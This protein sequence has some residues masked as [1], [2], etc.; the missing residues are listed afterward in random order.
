MKSTRRCGGAANTARQHAPLITRK[1][2]P[3]APTSRAARP[4]RSYSAFVRCPGALQCTQKLELFGPGL[5]QCRPWRDPKPRYESGC[6]NNCDAGC[7]KRLETSGHIAHFD[8]LASDSRQIALPA[9]LVRDRVDQRGAG[10]CQE[11]RRPVLQVGSKFHV[12]LL[13]KVSRH[14]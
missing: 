5:R 14:A 4:V 10:V 13:T 1:E 6:K 2:V 12:D 8:V 9:V 11:D 3:R 7:S